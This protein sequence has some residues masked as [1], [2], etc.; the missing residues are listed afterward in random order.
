MT[1]IFKALTAVLLTGILLLGLAVPGPAYALTE[2]PEVSAQAAILM[3]M[4]T[5]AVLFEKNADQ[6]LEP[7]SLTKIMT[8]LLAIELLDPADEVTIDRDFP[9]AGNS[10]LLRKGE[11]L[12]VEELLYGMLVHSANDAAIVLAEEM[13]GSVEEFC[14]LADARAKEIGAVHTVY[15]NPNGRND[16]TGHVTTARD[17]ALICVEA[18]KDPLFRKIVGTK[19]Y[20]IPATSESPARSYTSTNRLLYDTETELTVGTQVRTPKYDGI[21]GIKTG[22]TGTAG[23]CLAAA[24]ARGDTELVAVILGE[25]KGMYRFSDGIALLDYGFD[26]Y[27]SYR[28]LSAGDSPGKAPVRQAASVKAA[29]VAAE[30]CWITLPSEASSSLLEQRI[31][32]REGLAA[33]LA[34]GSALG[35]ADYYLA[36]KK[37]ASFPLVAAKDVSKGG[38]WTL[39]GISDILA[40]VLFGLVLLLLAGTFVFSGMRRKRRRILE[41][42]RRAEEARI[43]QAREEELANKRRRDWPY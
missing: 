2:K 1:K 21:L 12:T 39:Y 38:P 33:P 26:N 30:D 37:I 3:D 32:W 4:K 23:L 17:L 43:R 8:G 19:Q 34:K 25:P 28:V 36:G 40:Y 35:S 31:V 29:G 24:A 18:M 9:E 20:T 15:K 10:L 7:A 13:A 5:G 42:K 41:R 27:Y 16:V 11:V 22:E 6:I 14:K